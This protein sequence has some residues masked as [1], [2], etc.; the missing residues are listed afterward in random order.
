MKQWTVQEMKELLE[1][2]DEVLRR[3]VIALYEQQTDEEQ[4]AEETIVKNGAGYNGAD[5]KIMS[6]LAQFAI[7]NK[8]LTPK[9]TALARKKIMKYIKQ[10]TDLANDCVYR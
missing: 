4:D 2:N 7:K 10:L 1:T 3:C 6:S 9:Q 5:A 8:F